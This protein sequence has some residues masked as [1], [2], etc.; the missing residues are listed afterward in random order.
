MGSAD[1]HW[2]VA[3]ETLVFFMPF[4]PLRLHL[5]RYLHPALS[6]TTAGWFLPWF[7]I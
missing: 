3:G 7:Q 2:G 4:F 6:T 5:S 1:M